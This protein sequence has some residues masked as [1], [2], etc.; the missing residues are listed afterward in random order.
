MLSIALNLASCATL[1]IKLTSCHIFGLVESKKNALGKLIGDKK[2]FLF[3]YKW[4]VSLF[5]WSFPPIDTKLVYCLVPGTFFPQ[6]TLASSS[7]R[8]MSW[9]YSPVPMAPLKRLNNRS[10]A[11]FALPQTKIVSYAPQMKLNFFHILTS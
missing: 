11:L 3:D 10:W 1:H 5:S 2:F 7:K 8:G 6:R 4:R 9:I